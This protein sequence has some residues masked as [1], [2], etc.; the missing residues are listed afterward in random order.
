MPGDARS[1]QTYANHRGSEG[2]I[3]GNVDELRIVSTFPFEF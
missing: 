2:Q 3:D 1:I